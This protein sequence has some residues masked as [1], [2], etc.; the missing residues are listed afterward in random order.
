MQRATHATV[1]SSDHFLFERA[2]GRVD[3]CTTASIQDIFSRISLK[4][5]ARINAK[6]DV[7]LKNIKMATKEIRSCP[8]LDDVLDLG[9]RQA[10]LLELLCACRHVKLAL[11]VG[12]EVPAQLVVRTVHQQTTLHEPQACLCL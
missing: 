10:L 12:A 3:S 5:D 6:H 9:L 11:D 7:P 4:N 1:F 2:I 8:Y